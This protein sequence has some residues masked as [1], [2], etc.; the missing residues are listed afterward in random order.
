MGLDHINYVIFHTSACPAERDVAVHE[1]S[2]ETGSVSVK[3][4]SSV[5]YTLE[6]A[7]S[8]KADVRSSKSSLN[9]DAS[10]QQHEI[11]AAPEDHKEQ[12]KAGKKKAGK[13]K[14]KEKSGSGIFKG[15][16]HMFRLATLYLL[17][18]P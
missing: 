16:G 17:E 5:P 6:S 4:S 13:D 2:S 8:D 11:L 7:G 12:R 14:E 3:G 18:L 9:S 15:L 1:E 10:H